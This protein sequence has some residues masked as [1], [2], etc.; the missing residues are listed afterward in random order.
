MKAQRT[1]TYNRIQITLC[2][3]LIFL[4]ALAVRFNTLFLQHW[5]GDQSQYVTLAM[6]YESLG[7]EGYNLE[8]AAIR[9]VGYAGYPEWQFIFPMLL[10]EGER[11][12]FYKAY[13][14]FGLEFNIMPL[15]YKSPLFPAALALSHQL[16]AKPNQP[17]VVAKTHKHE[18]PTEIRYGKVFLESQFWAAV[19]PLASNLLVIL[20]TFFFA[21]RLFDT[22]IAIYAMLLMSL[23]PVGIVNAYKILA[24]DFAAFFV[25][26]ALFSFF[27]ALHKRS[28]LGMMMAGVIAGLSYLAKPNAI[29]ILGTAWSY[30]VLRQEGGG[31]SPR[32]WVKATLD[33]FFI[34]FTA[35]SLFISAHWFLRVYEVYGTFFYQP[36]SARMFSED[37]SGW[38]GVVGERPHM[39]FLF[40]FNI[41]YLCPPFILGHLTL[42]PFVKALLGRIQRTLETDAILFLWLWVAPFFFFFLFR[43][44]S[45]EERYLLPVYPALAML[46]AY[47]LA[48]LQDYLAGRL[49]HPRV[50]Q[51][52]V[53]VLL[54]A[55][56]AW[57]IPMAMITVLTERFIILEPAYYV[58]YYYRMILGMV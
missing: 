47:G 4:S 17:F 55:T 20:L 11:G 49:E 31:I 48:K 6:K 33:P 1:L 43:V 39:L 36:D 56:M 29:L 2:V 52:I 57:S 42:I 46:S 19:V 54:I 12:D 23:H 27:L 38:F 8:R 28:Y 26:A 53:G 5:Q 14:K 13:E 34:L 22:R 32:A 44:E 16:F 25:I 35:A 9:Q 15:Y 30:L 3:L 10:E 45:R 24:D 18:K 21:R 51:A 37:A 41:P 50:A 58:M 7:L 40:L